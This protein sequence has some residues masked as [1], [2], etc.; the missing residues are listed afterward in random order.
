MTNR[1]AACACGQLEAELQGDPVRVGVCHCHAC[2]RRTGA[3]FG[4]QA[5]FHRESLVAV[6]GERRMWTR[7]GD[8]GGLVTYTLCVTCGSNLFW[9]PDGLPEFLIVGVGFFA[10]KEFPA[11]TVS[12]YEERMPAWVRL[13]ETIVEHGA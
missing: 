8:G 1:I 3:P 11:P 10:Q 12:V 5:R 13:P 9:E 2:Q 7:A 4:V 6:R